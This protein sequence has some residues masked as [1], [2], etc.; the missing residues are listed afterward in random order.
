LGHKRKLLRQVLSSYLDETDSP[1]FV[2]LPLYT[3]IGPKWT[4]GR[5]FFVPTETLAAF[6]PFAGL[7]LI[8]PCGTLVGENLLTHNVILYDIYEKENYNIALIGSTGSGKSTLIKSWVSRLAIENPEMVLITFDALDKREYS[9]GPDGKFESSFAAKVG[10]TLYT[11][12]QNDSAGLDPFKIF[13]NEETGKPDGR[14]VSDFISTLLNDSVDSELKTELNLACEKCSSFDDLLKTAGHD[15][16]RKLEAALNPLMFLFTGEPI[17]LN[18]RTCFV[19]SSLPEWAKDIAQFLAFSYCWQTI[20]RLPTN[21]KKMIVVD[22]G[23]RL[24]SPSSSGR[25]TT[26][27]TRINVASSYVPRIARTGRHYNCAFILATQLARD[28]FSDNS[29]GRPM[30]ESCSTKIVLRQD[31]AA[32]SMLSSELSLGSEE[33]RFIQKCSQGQGL[34][35]TP[36]GRV[37]FYNMLSEDEKKSFTTKPKEVKT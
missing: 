33:Q 22:E 18:P 6:F 13:L 34:L 11:F 15:L 3:G 16:G 5:W 23:W 2:Q 27:A 29:I 14:T 20:S 7:D 26:E 24:V 25:A 30:I 10:S 17:S 1:A 28:F 35:L 12:R 21:R 36:E 19:L 4:T 32:S 37:Q 31:E 8:D 9:L